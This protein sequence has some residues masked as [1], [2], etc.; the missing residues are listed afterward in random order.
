MIGQH[1]VVTG[2][3]S[4][5]GKALVLKLLA[6]KVHVTLLVRDTNKAHQLYKNQYP[7]LIKIVSC[8][9]TCQEDIQHLANTFASLP[10]ID[11]FIYSAGMGYFK[12]IDQ[13]NDKEMINTYQ[14]NLIAFNLLL[15]VLRP[16]INDDG[17]IVGITSQA[18]FVTQ[19]YA[20][21]YG[22][23][24]AAIYALL[25]ALRLEEPT[26]HIMTVNTGPIA[27]PFH[28]KA[29]PSNTYAKKVEKLMINADE[30]ADKIIKGILNRQLEIN[31][32]R[33]MHYML[34]MYQL[35]PRF[36]EKNFKRLFSNKV[37]KGE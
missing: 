36:A 7:E 25:N 24:K 9:L 8:D 22:A 35:A 37:D 27:T 12:A 5:L 15:S 6:K 14:L 13:H 21:H 31:A 16:F 33:W 30:L 34:K 2:G 1:Y 20:A 17:H 19:A 32:P 18:A 29:D 23:S 11:G 4:G 10:N 28:Q 3:T 26:L